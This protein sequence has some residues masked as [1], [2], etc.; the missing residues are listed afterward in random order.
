MRAPPKPRHRY[1]DHAASGSD[2]LPVHPSPGKSTPATFHADDPG[3]RPS[4]HGLQMTSAATYAVLGHREQA[5]RSLS[6]AREKWQPC[7]V[8]LIRN[9][10]R[11]QHHCWSRT[12]WPEFLIRLR[13]RACRQGSQR[14][15]DP[16]RPRWTGGCG[17]VR[18]RL[19]AGVARMGIWPGDL[20]HW[21]MGLGGTSSCPIR[22]RIGRGR[23]GSRGCWR[24][25]GIGCWSKPGTWS[26]AVTGSAAWTRVWR[27]GRGLWLSPDYVSSVYA[28]AEWQAAWA[29][30][31]HGQQRKLIAVRVRGGPGGGIA[32]RRGGY[33]SGGPV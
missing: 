3:Y 4:L 21:G 10:G 32:H 2:L 5:G 23:S 14:G 29:A 6:T 13:V 28:T 25:T 22:R 19:R 17:A 33:R 30:D 20:Q 31:P 12:R 8:S 16:G 15:A 18:C 24:R 1:I 9:S 7:D 27:A 11:H 26:R